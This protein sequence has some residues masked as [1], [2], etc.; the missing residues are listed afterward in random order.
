MR[1]DDADAGRAIDPKLQVDAVEN[2][3]TGR[4]SLARRLLCIL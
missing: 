1:L 3:L 2:G 4:C